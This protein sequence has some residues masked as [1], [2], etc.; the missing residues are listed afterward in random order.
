MSNADGHC[1]C[2]PSPAKVAATAWPPHTA[3]RPHTSNGMS[4]R[5]R[6]RS[7]NAG[8]ESS[9]SQQTGWIQDVRASKHAVRD[10]CEPAHVR[11]HSTQMAADST[12]CV[13]TAP[14]PIYI[15]SERPRP[16]A[17]HTCTVE[18]S[19]IMKRVRGEGEIHVASSSSPPGSPSS[20]G[21]SNEPP[22]GTRGG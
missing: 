5:E 17:I 15:A 14:M 16:Y 18:D 4:P 21:S 8:R 3:A 10:S 1:C 20:A 19:P 9:C 12:S 2:T 6:R 22:A 7:S 11:C 13:R